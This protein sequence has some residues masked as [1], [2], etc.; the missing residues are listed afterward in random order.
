MNKFI[1]VA[2]DLLMI[3]YN[4]FRKLSSLAA[5]VSCFDHQ[6]DILWEGNFYNSE[7]VSHNLTFYENNK[8]KCFALQV[9]LNQLDHFLSVIETPLNLLFYL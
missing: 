1:K 9:A 4:I 5:N 8:S 7:A 2:S 6:M 3:T